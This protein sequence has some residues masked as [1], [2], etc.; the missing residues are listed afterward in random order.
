MKRIPTT[1]RYLVVEAQHTP[2]C[3]VMLGCMVISSLCSMAHLEELSAYLDTVLRVKEATDDPS[4]IV[5]LVDQEVTRLG[6]LREPTEQLAR[7]VKEHRLDALFLHRPWLLE[8]EIL[9]EGVG[10]LAYHQAFDLWMTVGFNRY[11]ASALGFFNVQA[12][13]QKEGLPLGMWGRMETQR[14]KT[15][16]ALVEEQ[17]GAL[18][19]VIPPRQNSIHS[20]VVVRA[21]TEQLVQEAAQKGA[22][23]Y[24]TGQLRQPARKVVEA[25]GIGVIATGHIRAEQWGLRRLAA[26]LREQFPGLHVVAP[27][28]LP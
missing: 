24:L 9:P 22:E 26:L 1:Q 14:W 8:Q 15:F 4:G 23:V 17:F 28:G 3:A 21:M 20:V 7:W 27:G 10:V 19:T 2:K 16:Y 25:T 13:G 6:M 5:V 12:F 11:L 18:E